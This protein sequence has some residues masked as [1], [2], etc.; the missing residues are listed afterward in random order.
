MSSAPIGTHS[1]TSAMPALPGAHQSLVS[2][3]EPDSAQHSACSRP[4]PPTTRT[5]MAI[6][7][8]AGR[9]DRT[10]GRSRA[11]R[12]SD[13]LL[14]HAGNSL[15]GG[16]PVAYPA[17][18]DTTPPVAARP[19]RTSRNSPSRSFPAPSSARWKAPSA[20]SGCGARSP[21]CRRYPSGHIYL[22]LKDENAKLKAVI[23]KATV[24]APRPEA[25]GRRR[26]HRHRQGHAP[27]A[28]ARNT[29]WSSTGWNMPARA[30]C[31]RGS[32]RCG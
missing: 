21:S 25:R 27:M 6:A 28:T 24:P 30:R 9:A 29:S 7:P 31:W 4:P 19:P 26:G 14:K 20:G 16:G 12:S 5:F 11:L 2:I 3:E 18:M 13:R 1:A 10:S 15:P 17:G 22:A 23:W 8:S 32:R